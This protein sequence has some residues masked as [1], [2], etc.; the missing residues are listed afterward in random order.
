MSDTQDSFSGPSGESLGFDRGIACH[1]GLNAAVIFSHICFWLR[2]NAR[3]GKN[4]I[5][6]KV[7]M[8]EKITD[9]S[10]HLEFLSEKQVKTAI[11]SLVENEYLVEGNHNKNKFDRTTWYA[12]HD[13]RLKD[14]KIKIA[15][16][17]TGPFHETQGALPESPQGSSSLYTQVNTRITT[18]EDVAVLSNPPK[19]IYP[20][21]NSVALPIHDAEWLTNRY[22]E[23]L[24]NQA[25]QWASHPST[26]IN[27]TLQQALKW[28][29]ANPQPIPKT[30]EDTTT[31]NKQYAEALKSKTNNSQTAYFDVL[32]TSAEV[33]YF[34]ANA[35]PTCINYED[36]AFK[37]Q[38]ESALRKHK[39]I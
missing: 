8:Y 5:D 28:Y 10:E 19:T 21:L 11:T 38:L 4:I 15:K 23:A 25:V 9:I 34:A 26:K 16:S 2:Y 29:C 30:K 1:V 14:I 7:W 31:A 13:K 37:E 6:G 32:N 18:T 12:L 35:N 3:H 27:Q 33:G 39:L 36:N 17:P 22:P 20:C 24:V